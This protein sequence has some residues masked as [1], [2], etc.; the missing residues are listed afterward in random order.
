MARGVPC[1]ALFS[2]PLSLSM[3]LPVFFSALLGWAAAAGGLISTALIMS[4]F[5]FSPDW[6]GIILLYVSW[7]GIFALPACLIAGFIT[8]KH[9]PAT[10]RWW[11]P[12]KAA[13]LGAG[14]GFLV[15]GVVVGFF[16]ANR[17]LPF[18]SAWYLCLL[19]ALSGAVCGFSLARFKQ[20]LPVSSSH[21]P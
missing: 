13:L 17:N 12:N 21:H 16:L 3:K 11:R 20:K 6:L 14:W 5:V 7:S 9:L 2:A 15:M 18:L 19:A 8:T 1:V 10:S 4:G